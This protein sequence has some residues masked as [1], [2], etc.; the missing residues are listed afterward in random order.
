[1]ER[2]P[3]PGLAFRVLRR[4][5]AESVPREE[6]EERDFRS[7]FEPLPEERKHA[8]AT[9]A[10]ALWAHREL[11]ISGALA[12][13]AAL[14]TIEEEPWRDV[15]TLMRRKRRDPW[16]NAAMT[17]LVKLQSGKGGEEEVSGAKTLKESIAKVRVKE[18]ERKVKSLSNSLHGLAQARDRKLADAIAK[19][20]PTRELE[21]SYK[22]QSEEQKL[23]ARLS[24]ALE[25]LEQTRAGEEGRE[26]SGRN[27]EEDMPGLL[28]ESDEESDD[29]E[30]DSPHLFISNN[31]PDLDESRP[32]RVINQS[33]RVV[34]VT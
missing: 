16:R 8:L 2:T 9:Q 34:L 14:A 3:P 4:A 26:G 30:D 25:N 20:K 5:R 24:S 33:E 7:E 27:E 23:E 1:M 6:R 18:A 17:F 22:A 19:G 13:D 29:E 28:M 32:N 12:V 10:I 11:G 21:E 15:Y 31:T